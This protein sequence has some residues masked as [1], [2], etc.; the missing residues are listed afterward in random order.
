MIMLTFTKLAILNIITNIIN[1]IVCVFL[2]FFSKKS[3]ESRLHFIREI[4]RDNFQNVHN[5]VV[6]L[7]SHFQPSFK[8][9]L[10]E[11]YCRTST[12]N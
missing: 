8:M 2:R 5:I 7:K 1:A 10:T 9:L 6:I 12:Q 3:L 11:Q 4:F